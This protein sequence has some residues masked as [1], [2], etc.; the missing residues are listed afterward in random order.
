VVQWGLQSK[1]TMNWAEHCV[2]LQRPQVPV[3]LVFQSVCFSSKRQKVFPP[4]EMV[5]QGL[6]VPGALAT[7]QPVGMGTWHVWEGSPLAMPKLQVCSVVAGNSDG[8]WALA[9]GSGA[10]RLDI[11]VAPRPRSARPSRMGRIVAQSL[12]LRPPTRLR[13]I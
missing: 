7:R 2:V 3:I 13:R 12:R 5:V 9:A 6:L 1:R 11:N 4:L 10:R 8:I